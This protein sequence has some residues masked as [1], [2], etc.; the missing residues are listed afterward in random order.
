MRGMPWSFDEGDTDY[1]FQGII[2]TYL[3]GT[4]ALQLHSRLGGHEPNVLSHAK[5]HS[6]L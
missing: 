1:L 5:S 4:F 2:Y 6:T 3:C